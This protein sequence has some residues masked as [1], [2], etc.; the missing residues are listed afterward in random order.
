[1]AVHEAGVR[2]VP[3]LD[4]AA[5]QRGGDAV[6][7][8]DARRHLQAPAFDDGVDVR[9]PPMLSA[10]ALNSMAGACPTHA[11]SAAGRS[12]G[13]SPNFTSARW[14]YSHDRGLGKATGFPAGLNSNKRSG[15]KRRN[16]MTL[17]SIPRS[18]AQLTQ[19]S[20]F[21]SIS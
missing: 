15:R 10:Y 6:L 5:H 4:R 1:V 2:Q 18:C 3:H 7:K 14:T 19:S 21:G 8:V 9:E 12:S 11:W 13:A 20:R 17:G 16:A